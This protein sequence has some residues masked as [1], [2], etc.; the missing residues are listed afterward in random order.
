M[1]LIPTTN[2]DAARSQIVSQFFHL[3]GDVMAGTDADPRYEPGM[4]GGKLL[5]PAQNGADIGFGVDGQTF[6]RGR[7]G[8]TSAAPAT[9]TL[10]GVP[11]TLTTLLIAAGAAYLLLRK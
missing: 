5:G 7:A 1:S 9:P 2:D 4:V 6:Y 3:I 11:L 10:L 8:T